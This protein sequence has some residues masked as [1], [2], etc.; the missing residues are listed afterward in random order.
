MSKLDKNSQEVIFAKWVKGDFSLDD[1]IY[2]IEFDYD[3]T[4]EEEKTILRALAA[5]MCEDKLTQQ[6]IKEEEQKRLERWTKSSQ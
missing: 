2:W 5:Y 3:C 4:P 1:F 6:G